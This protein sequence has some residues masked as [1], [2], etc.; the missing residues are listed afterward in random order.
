MEL[1]LAVTSFRTLQLLVGYAYFCLYAQT[2][3]KLILV[4]LRI[5]DFNLDR[6]PLGNLDEVTRCVISG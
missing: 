1:I 6:Y 2:G 4:L 3:A 5:L